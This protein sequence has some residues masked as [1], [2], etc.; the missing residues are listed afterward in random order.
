MHPCFFAGFMQPV[1][2]KAADSVQIEITGW[3]CQKFDEG[4]ISDLFTS[5]VS[6]STTSPEPEAMKLAAS[7]LQPPAKTARRRK[8]IRSASDSK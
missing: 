3:V 7:T 2:G 1:Q 6:S 8:R 4:L 5:W